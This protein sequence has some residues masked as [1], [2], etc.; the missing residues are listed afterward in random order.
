MFT[1]GPVLSGS[2]FLCSLCLVI[3]ADSLLSL[4]VGWSKNVL[5]GGLALRSCSLVVGALSAFTWT[6]Y[7]KLLLVFEFVLLTVVWNM[8]TFISSVL[9]IDSPLLCS[10]K[11]LPL[12]CNKWLFPL[13]LPFWRTA[14]NSVKFSIGKLSQI[15]AGFV[16]EL[17][18]HKWHTV[19][20]VNKAVYGDSIK[21]CV[22]K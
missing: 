17:W 7:R 13:P 10:Q 6:E 21:Q 8:L 1:S 3:N 18:I 2:I 9:V 22:R 16:R 12:L 4:C 15:S 14:G 11:V 19:L 5:T 20:C